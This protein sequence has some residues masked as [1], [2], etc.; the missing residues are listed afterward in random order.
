MGLRHAHRG[1][2]A[3]WVWPHPGGAVP[4]QSLSGGPLGM[5]GA[6]PVG[7]DANWRWFALGL[8]LFSTSLD[9]NLPGSGPSPLGLLSGVVLLCSFVYLKHISCIILTCPPVNEESLKLMELVS[10]KP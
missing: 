8:G 6:T 2:G 1:A 10:Y 3:P 5:N 7:V 4:A 9:P